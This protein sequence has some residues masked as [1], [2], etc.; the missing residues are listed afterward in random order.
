AL[1][2][3]PGVV[4]RGVRALERRG[5][6]QPRQLA[7]VD[8]E[9]DGG[10]GREMALG[11]GHVADVIADGERVAARRAAEDERLALERR[12]AEEKLDERRLAGA[13]GAEQADTLAVDGATQA[14]QRLGRAVAL[15]DV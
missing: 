5:A 15:P 1:V 13:V 14:P 3:G 11:L 9:L 12:Q 10:H 7:G 8:A 6:R 2:L 4:Q